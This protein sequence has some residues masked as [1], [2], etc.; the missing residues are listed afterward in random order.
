MSIDK[1]LE[2]RGGRY[3]TIQD[4]ANLCQGAVAIFAL[5]PKWDT[6]STVHKECIHM[7]LHKISRMVSGDA[8]YS[9]NPHDIAGYAKLLEDYI[10]EVK[11]I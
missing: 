3:G 11:A 1:T 10:A 4:N 8:W 5:H 2:E 6:L 7:I 9:D